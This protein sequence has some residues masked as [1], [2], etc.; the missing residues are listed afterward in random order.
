[1][2]GGGRIGGLRAPLAGAF[3]AFEIVIGSYTPAAVAPVIAA[4]LTV[5]PLPRCWAV[6][7]GDGDHLTSGSNT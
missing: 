7:R 1:V 2:R 4:A 3:Y 5:S 6:S